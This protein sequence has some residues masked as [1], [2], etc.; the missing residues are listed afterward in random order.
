MTAPT[1]TPAVDDLAPLRF[2]P[3]QGTVVRRPPGRGY[4]YWVGGHK[5]FYDAPSGR[6]VLFYRERTPLEHG[7]GGRCALAVSEDG[8]A[9]EEVWSAE[10]DQLAASSIEVGHCVRAH[11]GEW[12]LYLSYE[13]AGARYWRIDVL[14]ADRLE[15]LD[16][17]Y[18][19][20]V[21]MPFDYGLRSLKDPVVYPTDSG[22]RLFVMGP[23]RQRP[24]GDGDTM[25]AA[26]LEA[27]LLAESE[28]G[29]YFPSLTWCFEAPNTDTW[30]GRRARLNGVLDYNGGYAAYFDGG[31]TSYDLY[32]EQCG[33][34]WSDDGRHFER[35]PTD[36]P[37]LA[38]PHGCVR[39]AYPC[40]SPHG[41][42][43]YYEF[44]DPD[45]GHE[46]RVHRLEAA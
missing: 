37:W 17:Q 46:L 31:R 1:T 43:V 45:G 9:F 10:K 12:R 22:Y 19:R 16:T 26:S 20:T 14:R 24:S 30:H 40:P 11:S 42:L 36:E 33:I 32:E 3:A 35:V 27:T 6:F 5:V 39:Y 34:A 15:D 25:H 28:D 21:L 2:D 8:V 4:G 41:T 23:A 13:M 29:L 7:R 38:S 18:R 44:T